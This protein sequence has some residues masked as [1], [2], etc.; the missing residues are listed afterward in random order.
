MMGRKM[1]E[2]DFVQRFFD[3]L[4]SVLA[5]QAKIACADEGIRA[6]E[7]RQEELDILLQSFVQTFQGE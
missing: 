2:D 6:C 7:I 3:V 4:G 5:E 1:N